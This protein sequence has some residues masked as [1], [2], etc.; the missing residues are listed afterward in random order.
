M[1][2]I[3]YISILA[4]VLLIIWPTL[5]MMLYC[6]PVTLPL[7]IGF[8]VVNFLNS[9]FRNSPFTKNHLLVFVPLII[10]LL[11]LLW[12]II[13][14]HPIHSQGLAPAWPTYVVFALLIIQL[15]VSI[16]IIYLMKGYRWFSIF[17]ALL[18][19]WFGLICGFIAGMSVTGDWL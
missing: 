9:P 14:H 12:A 17:A 7:V 16:G 15:I 5:E 3:L 4:L 2:R 8:C 18:E 1:R 10:P 19:F 11:I 13:M 6:W